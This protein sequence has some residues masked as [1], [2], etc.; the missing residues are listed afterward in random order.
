MKAMLHR[1]AG[2][3]CREPEMRE[4][5]WPGS[6]ALP[7][8]VWIPCSK[9]RGQ[10]LK[11]TRKPCRLQPSRTCRTAGQVHTMRHPPRCII[12][13]R[14][15]GTSS[16]LGAGHVTCSRGTGAMCSG[17]HSAGNS[18]QRIH[19]KC[20]RAGTWAISEKGGGA[21]EPVR[22]E[23]ALAPPLARGRARHVATRT[24]EPRP[25]AACP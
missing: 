9:G 11:S 12:S 16:T 8:F 18:S 19:T 23:W 7:H 4:R 14:S 13:S 25:P 24:R 15:R 10:S 6:V 1:S 2:R 17:T 20:G 22:R 3:P 21:G 5:A